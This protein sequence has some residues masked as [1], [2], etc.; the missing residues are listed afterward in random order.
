MSV[1]LFV[2][3][4]LLQRHPAKF[5]WIAYATLCKLN[6]RLRNSC[7]C[8]VFAD[9]QTEGAT[10]RGERQGHTR[11][12]LARLPRGFCRKASFYL[13]NLCG[14]CI[15]TGSQGIVFITCASEIALESVY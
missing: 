5:H 1:R 13:G 6:H 4:K 14:E 15:D 2:K 9:S 12:A 7:C 8:R 3:S 11:G 10:S